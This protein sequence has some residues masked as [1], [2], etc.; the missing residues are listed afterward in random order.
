MRRRCIAAVCQ[1][2]VDQP[3]VVINGTKPILPLVAH[4]DIGL[5]HAPRGRAITPIPVNPLRK[6]QGA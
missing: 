3:A 2:E 4:L 1:H 5:V 6:Y